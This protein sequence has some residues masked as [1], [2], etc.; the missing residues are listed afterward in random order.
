L[1]LLLAFGLIWADKK[2]LSANAKYKEKK[3]N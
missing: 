2:K 1:F 3:E